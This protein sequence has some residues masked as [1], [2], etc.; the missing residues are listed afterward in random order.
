M[1]RAVVA[2][3]LALAAC[4]QGAGVSTPSSSNL[5]TMASHV[6]LAPTD[7]PAFFDCL[8]QR[9]FT[10][11]IAH[12]GGA[13]PGY[14]E[15]A[16]ATLQHTL[17]R[18]PVFMEV[19]VAATSD[20]VLVL[21]HDDTV[22]R[23]TNGTGAVD[24]LA[25]A[26]FAVLKLRDDGGQVLDAHPP[27]L[28][29]ALDWAYGNTILA[30]DVKPGVSYEDVARAVNDAHAMNRVVFITYS[31][32]GAARLHHVAPEAM[33]FV[34][35]K[36]ES[37]LDDL[38]RRGVDL[39]H[40]VAWTGTDEPNAALNIALNQRGVEVEFGTL[41]GHTSWDARFANEGR[42]QYAAFADT[43]LQLISTGRPREALADLD[44]HD[45][46]EGYG[47]LQCVTTD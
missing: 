6:T 28:R 4:G 11:V 16:I 19:D 30:L 8:R 40:A 15:N 33:L 24:R 27:T 2:L 31:V 36:S 10:A 12:R 39:A 41:G 17:A 42:E 7:L 20:D 32:A 22:D 9:H 43:G 37:D 29:E 25:A 1:K 5:D 38:V 3:A 14:A 34:T 46:V 35:I 26:Q 23:T 47:P 13:M 44:A 45:N 21:M 18:A